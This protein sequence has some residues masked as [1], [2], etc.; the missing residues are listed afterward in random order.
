M[1]M[2]DGLTFFYP[3]P[4]KHENCIVKKL[5][6]VSSLLYHLRNYV[7]FIRLERVLSLSHMNYTLKMGNV[8]S[9]VPKT[10]RSLIKDH[11]SSRS[12]NKMWMSDYQRIVCWFL[13]HLYIR[14]RTRLSNT[15][16]NIRFFFSAG[17]LI[18]CFRV[19]HR[20]NARI[21]SDKLSFSNEDLHSRKNYK[22]LSALFINTLVIN[23]IF[24]LYMFLIRI[25][26]LYFLA[27][28]YIWKFWWRF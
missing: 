11:P 22:L 24:I 14:G 21:M 4:V 16:I 23:S 15:Q 3:K 18:S 5:L 20:R 27:C 17:E 1:W 9:R 2:S 7:S 26:I 13:L 6:K 10:R 28:Q 8:M 19:V 12:L 25:R